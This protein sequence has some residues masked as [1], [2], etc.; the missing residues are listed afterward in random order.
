MRAVT[1]FWRFGKHQW[2]PIITST[3]ENGGF[4]LPRL[5]RRKQPCMGIAFGGMRTRA[6]GAEFSVESS[7]ERVRLAG[8]PLAP[9]GRVNFVVHP[10]IHVDRR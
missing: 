7:I 2:I 8:V 9:A 10:G 1:S 6:S 5:F 4:K 3:E